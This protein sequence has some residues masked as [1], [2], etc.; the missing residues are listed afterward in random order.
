MYSVAHSLK[1]PGLLTSLTQAPPAVTDDNK[2]LMVLETLRYA[3]PKA[4]KDSAREALIKGFSQVIEEE[5]KSAAQN[6]KEE[7]KKEVEEEEEKKEEVV[8]EKHK[9]EPVKEEV[10]KKVY[11][12]VSLPIE[13]FI[14]IL[15]S[16]EL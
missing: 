6:K 9:K 15:K 13:V 16:D 11:S 10:P 5:K 1:V 12:I 14:E 8:E 2:V 3:M 4:L 7:E